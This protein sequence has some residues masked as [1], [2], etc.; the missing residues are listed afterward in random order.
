MPIAVHPPTDPDERCYRIRCMRD[1][2][3]VIALTTPTQRLPP[4][5]SH[6]IS[7]GTYCRTVHRRAIV[8]HMAEHDRAQKSA[9][10]GDGFVQPH[11]ELA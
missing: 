10:G 7:D 3:E 9:N 6:R 11:S 1:Q 2:G 5:T 8:A 4:Q